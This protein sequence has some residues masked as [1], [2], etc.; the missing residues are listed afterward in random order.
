[1]L[2]VIIYLAADYSKITTK[3][4]YIFYYR[5]SI[6]IKNIYKNQQI[7]LLKN[8]TRPVKIGIII[9][10]FGIGV[11][12]YGTFVNS[13]TISYY[14][15]LIIITGL[16]IY[17]AYTFSLTSRSNMNYSDKEKKNKKR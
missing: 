17:M 6:C 7:K 3:P 1:M 4:S 16:F 8:L 11:M 15:L 12:F 5:F 14:A 10:L 2:G 9:L 13:E